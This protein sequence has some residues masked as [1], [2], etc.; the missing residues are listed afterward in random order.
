MNR[1][2]LYVHKMRIRRNEKHYDIRVTAFPIKTIDRFDDAV[3]TL[4]WKSSVS[5]QI[6][7][8][9]LNREIGQQSAK[10]KLAVTARGHESEVILSALCALGLL[11][12][13][14]MSNS[15]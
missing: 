9:F 14:S 8:E 12:A 15:H 10:E 5:A 13:S 4:A 1:E 2:N 6:L 3:G 7:A 11:H